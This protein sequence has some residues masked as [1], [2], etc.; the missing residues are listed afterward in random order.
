MTKAVLYQKSHVI[1]YFV[2]LHANKREYLDGK[3]LIQYSVTVF[4]M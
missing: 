1:I 4:A 3:G 2:S